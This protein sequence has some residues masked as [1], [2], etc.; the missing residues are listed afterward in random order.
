[1]DSP[2][3]VREKPKVPL[4]VDEPQND[5]GCLEIRNGNMLRSLPEA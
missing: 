5:C 1:M 2:R 3:V 4:L